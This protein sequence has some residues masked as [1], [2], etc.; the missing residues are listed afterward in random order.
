VILGLILVIGPLTISVSAVFVRPL[1][2]ARRRATG[3]RS[4]KKKYRTLD[5]NQA[6]SGA[7]VSPSS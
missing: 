3:R 7:H 2:L 6:K 5:A 4:G 1:I